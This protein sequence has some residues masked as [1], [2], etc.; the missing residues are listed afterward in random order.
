MTLHDQG[1]S[2]PT[3]LASSRG[4]DILDYERSVRAMI[5]QI[6]FTVP[7]E[8]VNRPSFGVGV[9][10]AIFDPN[11]PFLA[12]RIRTALK[13]NAYNYLGRSVVILKVEVTNDDATL[14]VRLHFQ[15]SDRPQS[16]QVLDLD[17]ALGVGE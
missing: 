13:E 17:L 5:E 4:I 2:Y 14:S 15:T 8:R 1:F 7:G 9:Q 11:G 12:S 6:L 10:N 3:T 16:P